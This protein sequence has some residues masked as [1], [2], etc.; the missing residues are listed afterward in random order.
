[1]TE[2]VD[3]RTPFVLG[4]PI[5]NPADFYGR[6]R[7]LR[8]LFRAVLNAELVAVVGEHRC[9]NTSIIYQMLHPDVRAR[10]L[11][12]SED[13]GLLFVEVSSQLAAEG[14]EAFFRRIARALR[15]ADPDTRSDFGGLIDQ[16]WLED[17]LEDLADRH[18]RLVLLVDEFEVL[19]E[20]APRFWE[21]FE[22][23]VTGYDVAMVVTARVDLSEFR[24]EHGSGP[25]F[26]NMFRSL[27][28]G[29][30]EP[31]TVDV[32]LKE[33][34]EIT[35]FDF[36]AARSLIDDLAGRFPYYIQ[37]AAALCYLHAGGESQIDDEQIE[38]VVGEFKVRT[39]ALLE[40]AWR[41]LPGIERDALT[42][43]ALDARPGRADEPAFYQALQSLERRAYVVDGRIFSSALTD[44]IRERTQ[45]ISLN[46]DTGKVR[47]EKQLAELPPKACALLRCL[48][49]HEGQVTTN[50]QIAEAVWPEHAPDSHLMSDTMIEEVVRQLRSAIE[51]EATDVQHIEHVPGVGYRFL[52]G[53]L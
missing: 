30:F 24:T 41:K 16:R 50:R 42:W 2:P 22:K 3:Q 39:A 17:Y 12:P 23:L 52:N 33:K 18:R 53:P 7:D 40:D 27:Y 49:R 21:W 47:I 15:R 37:V 46:E 26:F 20:F 31:E 5:K 11:E 29:S 48:I 34:S 51:A 35:D 13:N 1:M 38:Q 45:R 9:G 8:E 25:P 14:P 36:L 28:V 44:L 4:K 10:Y 19:A 32:F 6:K 43:L